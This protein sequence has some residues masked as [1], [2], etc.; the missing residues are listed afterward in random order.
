MSNDFAKTIPIKL[1]LTLIIILLMIGAVGYLG[2][3][4]Y[5]IITFNPIVKQNVY[6]IND[7]DLF[8]K[9]GNTQQ[10]PIS[11]PATSNFGKTDPFAAK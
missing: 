4:A 8:N 9:I 11:N 2:F 6:Q 1:I 5:L 7:Q 3:R 10:L